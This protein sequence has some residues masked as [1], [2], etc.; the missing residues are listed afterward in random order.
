MDM[1]N[2]LVKPLKNS[3]EQIITFK[4]LSRIILEPLKTYKQVKTPVAPL[5]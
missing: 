5:K 1:M 2:E 4:T 3:L